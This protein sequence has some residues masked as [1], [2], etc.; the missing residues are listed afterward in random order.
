MAVA[1][2]KQSEWPE[3]VGNAIG[4]VIAALIVLDLLYA[5]LARYF[6]ILR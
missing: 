4:T 6:S 3:K 1:N 5:P 2:D